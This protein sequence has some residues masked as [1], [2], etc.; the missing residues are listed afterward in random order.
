MTAL[1]SRAVL[2]GVLLLCAALTG[3]LTGALG[4]PLNVAA[5][6]VH[7]LFSLA[8][9]VF[10]VLLALDVVKARAGGTGMVV[11]A[12]AAGALLLGLLVTGGLLSF[13]TFASRPLRGVHAV[14]PFL[15]FAGAAAFAYLGVR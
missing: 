14:L 7:K 8:S 10:C 4:R 12:F 2:T 11:L 1:D 13:D 5:S 3:V 9:A 6:S 15:T